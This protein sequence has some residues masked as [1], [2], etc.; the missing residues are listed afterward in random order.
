M[1]KF[2]RNKL[3]GLIAGAAL[4]ASTAAFATSDGYPGNYEYLGSQR[5]MEIMHMMD[6]GNKGY[7]TKEEFM[8][9][10]EEMWKRMDKNHDGK[11]SP[12]EWLGRQLRQSDGG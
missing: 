3:L 7:V 6:K 4:L 2:N 5:P 1:I 11:V 12:E 8:K 10:H 9:F